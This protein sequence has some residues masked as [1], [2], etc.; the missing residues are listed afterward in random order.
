MYIIIPVISI[1]KKT[2]EKRGLRLLWIY[3]IKPRSINVNL[4]V[5]NVYFSNTPVSAIIIPTTEII[6]TKILWIFLDKIYKLIIVISSPS[7]TI[8]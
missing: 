7:R 5:M 8:N 2:I 6:K 4:V 1:H 3:L